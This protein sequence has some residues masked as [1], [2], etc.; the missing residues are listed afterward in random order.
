MRR[1][2]WITLAAVF[3]ATASAQD[4]EGTQITQRIGEKFRAAY[5]RS[6]AP[7]R[8][9]LEDAGLSVEDSGR[10]ADSFIDGM[11]SCALDLARRQA[12]ERSISY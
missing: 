12:E 9:M 4:D 10:I 1:L 8:D 11:L 6:G 5:E 7:I 3:W 2:S